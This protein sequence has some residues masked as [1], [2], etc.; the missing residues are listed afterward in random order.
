M[1]LIP[2]AASV[3]PDAGRT[4]GIPPLPLLTLI[5]FFNYVDRQVVYGMTPDIGKAF[6]LSNAKLGSLALANLFV[7]A[8]SSLISGPIADRVGPRKVIFTGIL[9]WSMATIGSAL[10][11]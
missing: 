11:T 2:T 9:V 7:F 8:L 4:R 1:T 5:N 10:S 3:P 6:H